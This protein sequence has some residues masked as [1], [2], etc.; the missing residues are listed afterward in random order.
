MLA[1]PQYR[2]AYPPLPDGSVAIQTHP[3]HSYGAFV[4]SGNAVTFARTCV[5][6]NQGA[7]SAEHFKAGVRANRSTKAASRAM[8]LP[9]NRNPLVEDPHPSSPTARKLGRHCIQ[10]GYN[11]LRDG[12]QPAINTS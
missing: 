9:Y 11:T 2:I 6:L 1:M 12:R 7:A 3:P 4:T 5:W 10:S 8:C